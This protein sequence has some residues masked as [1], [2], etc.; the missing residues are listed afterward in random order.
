MKT[1][2]SQHYR[3]LSCNG[4]W[5]KGEGGAG[6]GGKGSDGMAPLDMNITLYLEPSNLMIMWSWYMSEYMR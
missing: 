2:D 3:F 1:N 6:G 4:R 5:S